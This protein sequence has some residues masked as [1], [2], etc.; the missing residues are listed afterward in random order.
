M[1]SKLMFGYRKGQSTE[2]PEADTNMN[3]VNEWESYPITGLHRPLGHHEFRAPIIF[4]QS[5]LHPQE[6]SQVLIFV[7][8]FQ[9]ISQ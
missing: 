2:R 9:G 4:G 6:M 1:D 8:R 5:P 3:I 7:K